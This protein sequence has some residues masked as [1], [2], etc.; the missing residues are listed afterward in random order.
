MPLSWKPYL[1]DVS[2]LCIIYYAILFPQAQRNSSRNNHP[3]AQ[4]RDQLPLQ[5]APVRRKTAGWGFHN[6]GVM[7]SRWSRGLVRGHLQVAVDA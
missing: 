1:N 4:E 2:V 3:V 7:A 5:K 6:P